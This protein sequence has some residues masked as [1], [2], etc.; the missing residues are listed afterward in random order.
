[1]LK[2]YFSSSTQEPWIDS[3]RIFPN[4]TTG[5]LTI[6]IPGTK[7]I[8]FVNS[9]GLICKSLITDESIISV[10]DLADGIYFVIVMSTTNEFLAKEKLIKF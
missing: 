5:Y 1:M 3:N 9:T 2:S 4:P 6:D 8:V 7:K 10:E